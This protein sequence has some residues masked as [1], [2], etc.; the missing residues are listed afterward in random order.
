[1]KNLLSILLLLALAGCS[2]SRHYNPARKFSPEQL[3]E[4][5]QAF[6]NILEESHPS[7]YWYTPKDSMDFYFDA[8]RSKLRDS[9]TESGFRNVLTYVIAKMRCG[10][11]SVRGSKAAVK[12]TDSLARNRLFPLGVKIWDDTV[13]VTSNLHRRDSQ[14]KRGVLITA[15]EGKPVKTIIDSF[16]SHLSADGYNTT[17]KYQTLSNPGVFRAMYSSIYGLRPRMEVQYIDSLGN[18]RT[19]YLGLYSAA[20]DTPR[21]RPVGVPLVPP[22]PSRR[23]RRASRLRTIRSLRID[24]SMQAGIMDLNSFT[25]TYRLRSFFRRSFKKLEKENIPNL[26]IDLRANGGGSVTLSN[27]LTKYIAD[28]PFKIADSLFAITNRSAYR[29]MISNYL[30]NRIAFISMTRRGADGLYHFSLFEN[31]YF[32]PKRKNHF[33]GNV[34]ILTGGNTFSAA[35]LVTQALKKQD[36]VTVVGEETGGGAYGNTAWLIPEVTLPHSKVRFR[37]PLFRLVVDK[38][39]IKGFGVTPEVPSV[40]TVR[41]LRRAAD[42]KMETVRRLIEQKNAERRVQRGR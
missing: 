38:T 34:F 15:I 37:L 8:G 25:K 19:S 3:Q 40:P 36:N 18:A 22:S 26:V 35:T 33:D 7:L 39:A 14:V 24:T 10:H 31:R 9:L 20:A 29:K 17:H 23:E 6:R 32:K 16:F 1:M 21:V 41:D 27:L 13:M 28:Q 5:Y 42:F 30:M 4:D 2:A 12:F 11:T